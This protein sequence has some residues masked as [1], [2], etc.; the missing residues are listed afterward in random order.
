MSLQ[1]TAGL[2]GEEGLP[3]PAGPVVRTSMLHL[4]SIPCYLFNF[5]LVLNTAAYEEGDCFHGD[6]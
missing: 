1:G 3:G 2:K 5:H 4:L 6:G